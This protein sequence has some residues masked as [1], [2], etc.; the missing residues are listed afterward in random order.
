LSFFGFK[1][2]VEPCDMWLLA[3]LAETVMD[4]AIIGAERQFLDFE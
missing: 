4:V 2:D 1:A 3:A